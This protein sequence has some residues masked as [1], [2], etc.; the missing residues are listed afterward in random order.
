MKGICTLCHRKV[1]D[2]RTRHLKEIHGIP[3]G[4]GGVAEYF[5]TPEEV[6]LTEAKFAALPEGTEAVSPAFKA[7][8]HK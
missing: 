8:W 2:F 6:G 7:R 3:P 4:K 5:L 1:T